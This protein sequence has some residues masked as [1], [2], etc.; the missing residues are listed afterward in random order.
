[1]NPE[2]SEQLGR[3]LQARR[4]ERGLSTHKLASAA[5]MDQ[6]T[7]VR[8]EAGSFASPRADKLARIAEALD[9]SG[10]DVFALAGY[11]PSGDLPSLRPY[12]TARYPALLAEDLDRIEAYVGRIARK[13]GFALMDVAPSA[14][15]NEGT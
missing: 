7:V 14:R 1:M 8:F 2:Q 12:F 15:A 3:Y 9:V 4:K 5:G 10:A 6:A 13:R 11:M